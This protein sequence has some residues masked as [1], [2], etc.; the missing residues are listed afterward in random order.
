M[1]LYFVCVCAC[2]CRDG[3]RFALRKADESDRPNLGFLEIL[4]EFSH[5]LMKQDR[6]QLCV[7]CI[8]SL[9]IKCKKWLRFI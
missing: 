7:S 6:A 9:N 4:S 2:V 3:I 1:F 8:H 5:K